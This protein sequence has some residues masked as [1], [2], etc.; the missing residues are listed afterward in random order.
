MHVTKKKK[1][2]SSNTTLELIIHTS[3]MELPDRIISSLLVLFFS[4]V[5]Y[6]KEQKTR[7]KFS[8]VKK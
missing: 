4:C 6:R 3:N 7:Q 8:N 2:K 1:K 5:T